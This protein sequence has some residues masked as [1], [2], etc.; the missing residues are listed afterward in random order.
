[1]QKQLKMK[2]RDIHKLIA[3]SGGRCNFPGCGENVIYEYNDI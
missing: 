3:D 1:M 2:N